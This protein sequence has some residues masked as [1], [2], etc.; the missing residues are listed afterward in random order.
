M[1]E[2]QLTANKVS[3]KIDGECNCFIGTQEN[4]IR[5][6]SDLLQVILPVIESNLILDVKQSSLDGYIKVC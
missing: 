6:V 3:Y 4:I 2:S 1:M 5:T